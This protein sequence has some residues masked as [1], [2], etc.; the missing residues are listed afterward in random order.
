[1][2]IV[3]VFNERGALIRANVQFVRAPM[4]GEW[5]PRPGGTDMIQVIAVFH[6]WVGGQPRIGIRLDTDPSTKTA[7]DSFQGFA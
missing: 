5:V 6:G 7:P 1:M 2:D 3:D 4:V